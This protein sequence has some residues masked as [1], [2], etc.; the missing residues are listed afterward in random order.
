MV[1]HHNGDD[2]PGTTWGATVAPSGGVQMT[3]T[4][5]PTGHRGSVCMIGEQFHS[6]VTGLIAA[7]LMVK[8]TDGLV[9]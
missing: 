4:A 5:A 1:G 9:V 8:A 7:G 2:T 3:V 6:S